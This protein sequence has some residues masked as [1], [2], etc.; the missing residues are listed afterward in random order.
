MKRI[1]TG[2]FIAAALLAGLVSASAW[3]GSASAMTAAD[4]CG[5]GY[6]LVAKKAVSDD[7]HSTV[8]LL[9]NK[10][11]KKFCAVNLSFGS[12]YG[13]KRHMNV[14]V[15]IYNKNTNSYVH[16]DGDAGNFKYYAGPTYVSY[17]G[18]DAAKYHVQ[19]YGESYDP[20]YQNYGNANIDLTVPN[21]L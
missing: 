15:A 13:V 3:G 2:N 12:R 16:Q 7:H 18:L 5:S 19:A 8:R 10:G 20:A 1:R 9:V 21:A 17:S 4:V 14:K 11:A 6:S